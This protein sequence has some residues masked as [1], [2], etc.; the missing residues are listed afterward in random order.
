MLG[1]SSAPA[2]KPTAED[3]D[4]RS[5]RDESDGPKWNKNKATTP[6]AMPR[7]HLRRTRSALRQD[8]PESECPPL[9]WRPEFRRS[10]VHYI[11]RARGELQSTGD[12]LAGLEEFVL[13]VLAQ[14]SPARGDDPKA[15]SRCHMQ[16]QIVEPKAAPHPQ[17][18]RCQAHHQRHRGGEVEEAAL[19]AATSTGFGAAI[20]PH[21][22]QR[23]GGARRS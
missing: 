18:R 2:N 7:A 13:V 22:G 21:S 1:P 3:N 23:S 19:Y 8:E 10:V 17:P 14:E 9:R 6:R 5:G 11:P 4:W 12:R 15:V 16:S 20:V